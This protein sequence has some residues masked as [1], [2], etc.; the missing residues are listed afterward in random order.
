M[1]TCFHVQK[2]ALNL[3]DHMVPLAPPHH[4][5]SLPHHREGVAPN[6]SCL[7]A[8]QNHVNKMKPVLTA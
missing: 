5:P 3:W 6:G 4:Y 1:S 8:N 2:T 7:Q